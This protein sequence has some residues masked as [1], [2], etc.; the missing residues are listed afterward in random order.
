MNTWFALDRSRLKLRV[1]PKHAIPVGG[2]PS[3]LQFCIEIQNLSDFAVTIEEVGV[4]YRG[5]KERGYI[6]PFLPNGQQWPCRLEARSAVTVYSEKPSS[7][8]G[9]PIR[10]AYAK[11]SCGRT[12]TGTSGALKQIS[13]EGTHY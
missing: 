12:K 5:A 2:A 13:R 3:H 11:T 1:T 8:P 6:N 9:K 10:A 4:F 7:P